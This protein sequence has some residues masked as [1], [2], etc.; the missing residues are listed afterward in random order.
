MN[1]CE[2]IPKIAIA[3]K[4]N[5]LKSSAG[6]GSMMVFHPRIEPANFKE[7]TGFGG[8]RDDK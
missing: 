8:W 1:F 2:N 6:C 5:I 7:R 3:P 4:S